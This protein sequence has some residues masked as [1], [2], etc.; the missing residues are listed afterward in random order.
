MLVGR[1]IDIVEA[2]GLTTQGIYR[3]PGNAAAT[4]ALTE[5]VNRGFDDET[6]NDPRWEDVNVVSSLLKAFIRNLPEPIVPSELYHRFLAADKVA[7]IQ[8]L[9]K[10]KIVLHEFPPYSYE[11]LKAIMRHLNRVCQHHETNNMDARNIAIVFG[12]SV[13]RTT[14]GTLQSDVMDMKHQCQIVEVL[15]AYVS[16]H[17]RLLRKLVLKKFLFQ[18]SYFFEHGPLPDVTDCAQRS[19]TETSLEVQSKNLLLDNVA[20]IERKFP[21]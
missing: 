8:R 12:P 6:L 17:V 4:T 13:V 7:G 3:V 18:Y 10:L 16:N 1:C 2:K 20:K 19:T 21:M 11:T 5:Q 14:S 9:E 15:V